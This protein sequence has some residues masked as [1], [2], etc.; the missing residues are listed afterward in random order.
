MAGTFKGRYGKGKHETYRNNLMHHHGGA[1]ALYDRSGIGVLSMVKIDDLTGEVLDTEENSV[2]YQLALSELNQLAVFGDWLEAK[3]RYLTAKEQFEMV[4]K[5]FREKMKDLF[6][7]YSLKSIK[8]K[9]IEIIQK[10][11]YTKTSWDSKKL[12]AFIYQHGGDPEQFKKSTW[13]ESS[14]QMKYKE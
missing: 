5:P 2:K 14:L 6:E 7:R 12:E 10:N 1:D 9:Y 13:V 8:N 11:G 4:D 3:E